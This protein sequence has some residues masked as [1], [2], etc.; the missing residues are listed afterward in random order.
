MDITFITVFLSLYPP[1]SDKVRY[2]IAISGGYI[3]ESKEKLQTNR[4][5]ENLFAFEQFEI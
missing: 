1:L 3:I 4:S 5:F 2:S